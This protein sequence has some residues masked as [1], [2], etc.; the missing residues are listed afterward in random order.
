MLISQSRP[1]LDL[2]MVVPIYNEVENVAE[3]HARLH[4]VLD[5]LGCSFEIIA[6]DDGST[7]GT[8]EILKSLAAND[9]HLKVV[10]FRRNFGQTAGFAAGFDLAR[11]QTV[12]TIDADLQNDP[13]D[14]PLLLDKMAEGYDV[15]SGWRLHRQ[16]PLISRKIPSMIANRLISWVTGVYLHDYGCSL[17][18][19]DWYVVKNVHLYGELHRFIPALASY[20]GVRVAEIPVRHYPR[21]KGKSK[22]GIS[23][24]LR[25][26]LDLLTVRFLLSYSARPMQLFGSLGLGAFGC[27]FA[28]AAYLTVV[29]LVLKQDIG[30]RPLLLLAILLIMVGIQLLTM[31]LLGELVVRTYHE[32]QNKPIYAIREIIQGGRGDRETRRQGEGVRGK[33]GERERQGEGEREVSCS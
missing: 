20:M 4:A 6:V 22:Y 9:P 8:G 29:K 25:V 11:G 18:A 31:G 2:S 23:R 7:D 5:D 15:V 32:T 3:L 33:Q 17:K 24:T 1:D 12:I 14:I 10:R 27:G 30:D 19:Y 26:I 16:D 28:I 13:A 21:Q